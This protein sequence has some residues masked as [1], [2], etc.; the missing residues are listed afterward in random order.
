[1]KIYNSLLCYIFGHKWVY[2]LPS[3]PNK[4]ICIRCR[5]KKKLDLYKLEWKSVQN[6]EGEKRTDD[7]LFRA[8]K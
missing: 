5:S 8:W 2:N 7:E 1:M 3:Q 4:A 6:F